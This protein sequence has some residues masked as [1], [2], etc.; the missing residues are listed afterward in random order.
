MSAG[1]Q[2]LLIASLNSAR[3]VPGQ[4]S[5]LALPGVILTATPQILSQDCSEQNRDSQEEE[6][7]A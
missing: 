6:I 4:A 1:W 7:S 2:E 3:S 5:F